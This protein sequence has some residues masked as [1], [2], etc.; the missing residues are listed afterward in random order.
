MYGSTLKSMAFSL[1]LST[2]S[3]GILEINYFVLLCAETMPSYNR[4]PFMI[5]RGR[6]ISSLRFCQIRGQFDAS[7]IARGLFGDE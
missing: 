2:A 3:V 7:V 6:H 4:M 5:K 1:L